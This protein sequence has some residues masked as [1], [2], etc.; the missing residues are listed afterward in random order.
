MLVHTRPM[1]P[2]R[3][4]LSP[5]PLAALTRPTHARSPTPVALTLARSIRTRRTRR[6]HAPCATAAPL[7]T[8]YPPSLPM[9]ACPHLLQTP[10][11]AAQRAFPTPAPPTAP[12]ICSPCPYLPT[13]AHRTP[14]LHPPTCTAPLPHHPR[15][16]HSA[17]FPLLHSL[18]SPPSDRPLL[19]PFT[20]LLH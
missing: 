15:S 7:L 10:L 19:P 13:L 11:C 6:P 9:R 12:P 3:R 16:P 18:A 1:P 2:A 4:P 5:R 8:P 20:P 17:R 14:T